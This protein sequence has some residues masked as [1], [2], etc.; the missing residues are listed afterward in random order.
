MSTKPPSEDGSHAPAKA[1]PAATHDHGHEAPIPGESWANYALAA[2]IA[3]F[4]AAGVYSAA[5]APPEAAGGEE[6]PGEA[7]H[8]REEAATL[9]KEGHWAESLEK[10]T[11]AKKLDPAG[12]KEEAV[13]HLRR[14]DE[15]ELRSLPPE[16]EPHAAP[17]EKPGKGHSDEAPH[18]SPHETPHP[19]PHDP[20]HDPPHEEK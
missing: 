7:R 18:E 5:N 8:L 11:E 10:L 6:N 19:A 14:I 13:M 4:F 15:A 16:H 2:A 17:A 1:T 3:G 20:P 12:E 9:S